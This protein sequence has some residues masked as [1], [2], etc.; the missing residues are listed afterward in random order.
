MSSAALLVALASVWFGVRV[1]A[2]VVRPR[3]V[4]ILRW[5]WP[6]IAFLGLWA[7]SRLGASTNSQGGDVTEQLVILLLG[8]A[9]VPLYL[10]AALGGL[11]FRV[12]AGRRARIRHQT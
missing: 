10:L 7:L 11:A 9:Q 12:A 1:G 4:A 3:P 8:I 5:C 6:L 2:G